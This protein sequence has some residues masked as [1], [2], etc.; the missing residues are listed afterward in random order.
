M[1][2]RF[3][4]R[5]IP[6]VAT[7]VA[8]AIGISLGQWQSW[9]AAEKESIELKLRE[10]GTAAPIVVSSAPASIDAIEYRQVLVT[11]EF[12]RD[13][14]LYLDNRPHKGTAGLHVLLPLKL[15]GSDMHVM[16]ARGWIPRNQSDR[17]KLPPLV[18]PSGVVE[19]QGLVKRNA[20]HV[21]QLG[22]AEKLQPGA[23]VQN[24]DLGEFAAASKLRMQ[25]FILEQ[26]ND[27]G[28]GLLHDWP[29]PSSGIDKHRGYA[30]QWYGLSAT[31]FLFFVV[32]GFR[33][34]KK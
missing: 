20:G 15:A 16:V 34:G 4:F 18:T 7:L 6:F 22:Q 24:L 33:R 14:P 10:R 25:A 31:A 1:P 28:D 9:R 23:I 12:V 17:A 5:A 8:M 13:W 2:I 32:T 21:M 11:G 3:Q 26:Q 19:I 27:S 29:R 30:F